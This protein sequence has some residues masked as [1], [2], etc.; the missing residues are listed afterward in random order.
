MHR[1]QKMQLRLVPKRTVP[2]ASAAPL[3]LPSYHKTHH[4]FCPTSFPPCRP[5]RLKAATA[6]PATPRPRHI[7]DP[8]SPE[9][10]PSS[11]GRG[12]RELEDEPL[13]SYRELDEVDESWKRARLAWLC[14]ELPGHRA[15]PASKLLNGQ[16][17]W[18]RQEDAVYV[19]LHCLRVRENE[20]AY[21]IYKWMVQRPWY[22]LDFALSTKL[23]DYLGKDRKP[24]KCRD[25]FN[26][27]INQGRVPS[28]STF[29]I[30]IV[31]YLSAS[32]EGFLDEAFS[33]YNQMIHLG[34][35]QPNLAL[36]NSLFRAIVGKP[37]VLA[38]QYLKQAEFIY[39][40]LRTCNLEVQMDIYGGLIWLHSY[41]DEVDIQRI[42]FL[43]METREAGFEENKEVLVSVLRACTK[44]GDAEQAEKA[45]LKLHHIGSLLPSQA[46]VYKMEVHAKNG[47]FSK[48]LE[49]FREMKERLGSAN[50]VAYHKIIEILCKARSLEVAESLM[51]EF[52]ASDL[53]HLAPPL[54]DMLSMYLGLG[55]HD[56]VELK[57]LEFCQRCQPN[58]VVYGIYLDS[59]LCNGNIGKAEKIFNEMHE[60][61]SIGI[62]E[63]SCN[64]I[65]RAY[66]DSGCNEKAGK[67]YRIMQQMKFDVGS[68]LMERLGKVLRIRGKHFKRTTV[69]ELSKE[70]REILIGMLL[71]GL[72]IEADEKTRNHFVRFRFDD[73]SKMHAVLKR[74]TYEQF[75]ELLDPSCRLSD[76]NDEI[77]S[78]FFTISHSSLH[79]FA[80]Q[81][82]PRG[83][84]AIPKLIH[85][86]LS[87]CVL[88]YWYMYGG[89]K[90]LSG[91]ILLK[92][93]GGSLEG[94]ERIVKALKAKSLECR[95]KRRGQFYWIGLLGSNATS[96]WE[97]MQ[98]YLLDTSATL[99]VMISMEFLADMFP[100]NELHTLVTYITM[101][102]TTTAHVSVAYGGSL[103]AALRYGDYPL[104]CSLFTLGLLV[105]DW[106]GDLT[107]VM[108][109]ALPFSD[110]TLSNVLDLD[111]DDDDVD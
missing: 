13:V 81:F 85:R 32:G 88:A 104:G 21:R 56:K 74:R 95:V 4:P 89:R 1:D 20:T 59:L 42:E 83:Q 33:I 36:H 57:F 70:H 90:T 62:S 38:K 6:L 68:D 39:H 10:P 110:R 60:N 49:T 47:D 29:H 75:H 37:G 61:T 96:A 5:R 51:E 111:L 80:D 77:P 48:S 40:H 64:S 55:L 25:V 53:K 69:G 27:I 76:A 102:G 3:S 41:Q 45:W 34:G 58:R 24:E 100:C 105:M 46:Y 93:I 16:R 30:L 109:I 35:Y 67:V 18:L 98:P 31:S 79:F 44:D 23:A 103:D 101:G 99:G 11:P 7:I 15:G 50:V 66:L 94:V 2:P 14:K 8:S 97:L 78:S 86:W 9:L 92:L 91:D 19:L 72:Q 84:P 22:R 71:G 65:L 108:C 106:H 82:L 107:M 63:R 26:D 43:R 28:V 54:T 73:S 87:P 52:I 17:K 12:H